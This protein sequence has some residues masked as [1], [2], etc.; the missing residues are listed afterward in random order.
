MMRTNQKR[1]LRGAASILTVYPND[2]YERFV[3]KK[4][5]SQRIGGHWSSV[6]KSVSRATEKLSH[7]IETKNR[8]KA[9]T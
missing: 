2:S 4:T 3:S 9:K 8:L 6:G 1:I 7:G 5:A